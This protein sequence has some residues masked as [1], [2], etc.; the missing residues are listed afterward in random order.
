MD[1][2]FSY[3]GRLIFEP[4]TD[5]AAVAAIVRHPSI[6]PAVCDD[7]TEPNGPHLSA[8]HIPRH[9]EYLLVRHDVTVDG[10]FAFVWHGGICAGVHVCLF[11]GSR[12]RKSSD[13]IFQG[14]LCW[15]WQNK[16]WCNRLVAEIPVCNRLAIAYAKRNGMT[17]YGRNPEAWLKHG[18]KWDMLCVGISR[19]AA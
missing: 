9:S 4:T 2:E 13:P 12:G 6:W 1:E 19:P 18:K 17:E 5:Y 14:M 15:V 7:P 10:L 3:D 16:P 11:P 8:A